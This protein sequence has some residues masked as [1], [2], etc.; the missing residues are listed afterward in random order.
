MEIPRDERAVTDTDFFNAM[1]LSRRGLAP[2]RRAVGVGD[3]QAARRETV[4]YFRNRQRPKWFFDRRGEIKELGNGVSS[5]WGEEIVEIA[6]D[7]LRHRF[8]LNR[9]TVVYDLGPD[10]NWRTRGMRRMWA[11][12]GILKRCRFLLPLASAYKQTGREVYAAKLTELTERWLDDWPLVVDEDFGSTGT[13]FSRVDGHTAMP[14]ADRAC[15]WLDLMYEGML[16][17][18]GVPVDTAFRLIKSTWFTALQFRRYE[19]APYRPANHHLWEHGTAPFLFGTILPEF[20]EVAKLA[21]QGMA[22]IRRHLARSFLSDGGYEERTLYYTLKSVRMF[23]RPLALAARNHIPLFDRRQKAVL[24]SC[25]ENLALIA[26]PDGTPPDVGDGRVPARS[27][28]V[29]LSE[30]VSILRSPVVA[31]VL[32]RLRLYRFARSEDRAPLKGV[33]RQNLPMTLHQPAS[34]YF[35]ARSGWTPRSS[36]MFLSVPGRGLPTHAH[37]DALSLH[38]VA[39]GE[40]MIGTPMSETYQLPYQEKHPTRG[41]FY[42]MTSHNVVLVNGQ[43]ARS[44]EELSPKWGPEPIPVVTE[45]KEIGGGI[46]VTGSHKGYPG[47]KL[48]RKVAFRYRK[49]WTVRD[50]VEGGSGKP[51]VARWHFEYGVEVVQENGRFVAERGGVRLGV[52]VSCDGMMRTRLYRDTR[53]LAKNPLRNGPRVPWVLDVALNTTVDDVFEGQPVPWVLDVT[54][55]GTGDDSLETVFENLKNG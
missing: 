44:I 45:W 36:A 10:L 3:L 35:V 8:R 30:A 52:R 54:F 16:F 38:L 23:L 27:N 9:G 7:V 22:V 5:P 29:F 34:G 11:G 20:P 50:R 1:D 13:V 2:V 46:Q 12:A 17:A 19:H 14:T 37:D 26:M 25:V 18:P 6:D 21:N 32:S 43:P 33:A 24:K 53:W 31:D 42:A 51:H 28:A 47:V 39:R 55:G 49:G 41:H 15:C 48:S 4:E 40:Q